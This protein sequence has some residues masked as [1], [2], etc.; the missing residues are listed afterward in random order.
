MEVLLLLGLVVL[1][2]PVCIIVLFV[3]QSSLRER[4]RLLELQLSGIRSADMSEAATASMADQPAP[5]S[6]PAAVPDAAPQPEPDPESQA[7]MDEAVLP[8]DRAL[9]QRSAAVPD[10]NQPLVLRADR[11]ADLG[12][13]LRDNWVYVVSALSLALAGV[14]FVQ[15]GMERGLLPPE[16]RVVSAMLFGA[17][18]IGCG[19][20]LR[21]RHGDEAGDTIHLPSVFSGAG[22]V[23]IFAAIVA[24]RQLYGLIGPELAFAGLFGTAA[25]AVGLGWRY[26]PLLVALGLLGAASAPFL[27]AGAAAPGPWLYGYFALIAGMG[28]AVD[29][30][31][32]WAWV[33]VLAL[34]LAY[35][36]GWL[37]WA[38]GA[39]AVGWTAMLVGL[40]L[41]ALAL[42]VLRLV[43]DQAGPALTEAA[44]ADGAAGWP[45][46]PVRLALG[47]ALAS[48]L[49]LALVEGAVPAEAMLAFAALALLALAFLVWADRAP[50]LADLA[51]IP[52]LGFL[53]RL[54]L[55]AAGHW[56]LA[57]DFAAQAIALRPPET[58]GP[59][60]ITLLVVLAAL[61]SGGFAFRALRG[62]PLNLLHALAA[63]LLA[64]M[65][66]A[67][68]ELFW[69]PSPVIGAFPWALQV[70]VLAAGMVALALR[71]A[72]LDGEDKRRL[73]WATL[74]ALALIALALFLL[75][76]K[77]AL[78]LALAAMVVVAAALD[79]RF[80]LPEM[81]LFIQA[82]V[83]VIGYRLLADPGVDW[84]LDAGLGAVLAVFVG[85][86]AALVLAIWLLRP[87]SRVVPMG[88]MESAAVGFAAVLANVL[89]LR[90]MTP[91]G[92]HI[93]V[94]SHH[95][96]SLNALPWLVLMLM[97][98]YRA[99]LGGVLR[100]LRLA[101]AALAA[102]LAAAGLA[103]AVFPLNP[104]FSFGPQDVAAWVLGP[105]VLDS[106]ALA[107]L[108]PGLLLLAAAWKLA[109]LHRAL[110]LGFVVLGSGLSVL[111]VGLEIRRVWQGD[112]LGLGIVVQPEL[113]SYTLALMLLGAGLLYQAIARRSALL[114]RIA[115]AVI[116]VVVAKVFLIDA[117]GL[118][119]LTR[120]LSF[121]GLGLSLAGLAWLNRW[122]GQAVPGDPADPPPPQT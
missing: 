69:Q 114:R 98:L 31:R 56:P 41:L 19:E 116:A 119:G 111:Y 57:R 72:G 85:T 18:L 64:P 36:G 4:I 50:G 89:I 101:I 1:A 51:V 48:S 97:Q 30:I 29:A 12:G 47:A 11:F 73:A 80:R 122:A 3:G 99:N 10:Q 77:T 88:V 59:L 87:M 40:A 96:A 78:T 35:G 67:G 120:V 107:Y 71:F 46:F 42:P 86:I 24:A 52:A 118:T 81:G 66:V 90:W 15:Y 92:G 39:G 60:T 2:I 38:G 25:L 117:A 33:S 63:V 113:Y 34:V 109:S 112:W 53:A 58:A 104:L 106:L 65:A 110:W 84:A 43:P 55:E 91:A 45:M 7:A 100:P 32:R 121:L 23:S 26:G 82:G 94:D 5:P 79:R 22:L 27:V 115:M 9:A 68:I 28:L 54:M 49:G 62:G 70:I 83:A 108:L 8:W 102:V 37:M 44:L 75:T 6:L 74:S 16:L 13:W 93:S 17:G 20:W 61:I 105:L 14:F 21:R 76:T 95:E 103:V